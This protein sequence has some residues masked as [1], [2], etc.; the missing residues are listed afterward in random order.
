MYLMQADDT[1][2][3][4][5]EEQP[6]ESEDS[7]SET[8][9]SE[10]EDEDVAGEKSVQKEDTL[11]VHELEDLRED[12]CVIEICNNGFEPVKNFRLSIQVDDEDLGEMETDEEGILEL[13]KQ[14]K[15]V[16]LSLP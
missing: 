12:G 3:D 10:S 5:A 16:K 6:E 1:S 11:T 8:E 9:S 4:S 15:S 2:S 13:N 7:D 14:G